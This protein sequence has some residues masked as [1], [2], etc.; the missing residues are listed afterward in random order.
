MNADKH[1]RSAWLAWRPPALLSERGTRLY[2]VQRVP[3]FLCIFYD[4]IETMQVQC[5]GAAFGRPFV[6]YGISPRAQLSLAW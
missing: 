2:T 6:F 3:L 1:K 4:K 5:Q